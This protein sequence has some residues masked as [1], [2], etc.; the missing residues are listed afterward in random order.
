M[1]LIKSIE[2]DHLLFGLFLL[3]FAVSVTPAPDWPLP[4]TDESE[5]CVPTSDSLV[6]RSVG[7]QDLDSFSLDLG[8]V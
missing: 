5:A 2:A 4:V 1:C 7:K 3:G 8:P 6:V